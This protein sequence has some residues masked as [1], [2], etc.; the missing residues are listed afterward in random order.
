M[1]AT[2]YNELAKRAHLRRAIIVLCSVALFYAAVCTP[3]YLWASNDILIKSSAFSLVWDTVMSACNY[4]FYWIALAM[5]IYALHRFDLADCRSF[6]LAFAAISIVRYFANHI[7]GSIVMG[8]Q[9]VNSF[10]EDY[11]PYIL[12]DVLLDWIIMGIAVGIVWGI[13]KK[14]LYPQNGDR[15]SL[16]STQL[17]LERL[18]DLHGTLGR[19]TLLVAI[20]PS[21]F[22]MLSRVIYDLAHGAPTGLADLLW[23]ITGYMIDV[24]SVLIGYIAMLFLLNKFYLWEHKQRD[25]LEP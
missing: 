4:L 14:Q 6:F 20:V 1:K 10:F 21:A 13:L 23:I 15:F 22:H 5:L 18:F 25:A 8:F 17:P 12:I 16:L 7:A 2:I 19:S 9:S 3:V 11:L 24:L